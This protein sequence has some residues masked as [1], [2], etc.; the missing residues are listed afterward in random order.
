M[1]ENKIELMESFQ[2]KRKFRTLSRAQ[3]SFWR[4]VS[5]RVKHE[6]VLGPIMFLSQLN[7]LDT[8]ENVY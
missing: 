4:E 3:H 5:S 7:G 2:M 1:Y 8:G 6:S